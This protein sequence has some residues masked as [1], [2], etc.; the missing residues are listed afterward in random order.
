[1]DKL[2]Q[3]YEEEVKGLI[4]EE[5]DRDTFL[6]ALWFHDAIYDGKKADNEELSC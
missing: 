6:L 2:V 5:R 1:M 4:D 3:L